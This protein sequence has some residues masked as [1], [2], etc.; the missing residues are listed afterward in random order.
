[1][2]LFDRNLLERHWKSGA[3]KQ[4]GYY[5]NYSIDTAD[6]DHIELDYNFPRQMV[7][8]SLKPHDE[9]GREFAVVIK[10]G[11]ILQERELNRR[12]SMDLYSRFS[13]HAK[14]FAFLRDESILTIIGGTYGFPVKSVYSGNKEKY[15]SDYIPRKHKKNFFQKI[16]SYLEKKH[17]RENQERSFQDALIRRLPDEILDLCLGS[18]LIIFYFLGFFSNAQLA[19]LSGFLGLSMGAF[20]WVWRQRNP[21]LPK[22]LF[23]LSIS[24]FSVYTQIQYRMWGIFL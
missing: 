15:H 14:I 23:M 21:F 3:S 8:I 4:E 6:G 12:R 19:T 24:A 1:M 7:R 9:P 17:L 5:K 2:N 20:D 13:R 22:V 11:T 16:R 10:S 18:S